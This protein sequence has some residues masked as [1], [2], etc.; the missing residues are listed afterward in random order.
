M[1][2]SIKGYKDNSPDRGEKSLF[3]NS[4]TLT[5]NGVSRPITAIPIINGKPDY[6]QRV[7]L[8]PG[9]PDYTNPKAQGFLEIP[10][11]Q[12][13][14]TMPT[15]LGTSPFTTNSF[16]NIAYTGAFTNAQQQGEMLLPK[17]TN[18]ALPEGMRD[19]NSYQ[20]MMAGSN[21]MS[22]SEF[23]RMTGVPTNFDNYLSP[24]TP[25]STTNNTQEETSEQRLQKMLGALNNGASPDLQ[26]SLQNLGWS[27][28]FNPSEFNHLSPNAQKKLSGIN[29]GLGIASAG[30][31][32]M[33]GAFEVVS[34]M[35]A[36][37]RDTEDRMSMYDKWAN[38]M[39]K[40][41]T[42][43]MQDGGSVKPN[44]QINPDSF[45]LRQDWSKKGKGYFG[46]LPTQSGSV[47][48]EY[49]VGFDYGDVPTLTPD[50]P[51]Y[52]IEYLQKNN[53]MGDNEF[54]NELIYTYADNHARKRESQGLPYFATE[55][56]EG[57]YKYQQGGKILTDGYT[58]GLPQGS[59]LP[60][61]AEVEKGE[62]LKDPQTGQVSEVIGK[63]HSEGGEVMNLEGGTK[64]ISDY[65]EIGS[66]LAREFKKEFDL[67]NLTPK[68]T[69]A[70]VLKR[71]R[72]SIGLT[73]KYDELEKTIN[74]IK[75]Q[76]EITNKNT[77]EINLQHLSK[78]Y[79][80]QLTE[81]EPLEQQM[82]RF[83]DYIFEHQEYKK[84][85][86]KDGKNKFQ[87]GGEVENEMLQIVD[88]FCNMTGQDPNQVLADLEQMSPEEQQQALQMMVEAIQQAPQQQQEEGQEMMQEG[89]EITDE[90]V[91]QLIVTFAQATGANPEEIL[92][93]FQQM[94]PE[95]QTQALQQ[96]A[97]FLQQQTQGGQEQ[98]MAP[99]EGQEMMMQAGGES[100]AGG[101][102]EVMMIIQAFAQATGE[103]AEAIIQQLQQASPEE[104]Q[105]MLQQMVQ[106]LQEGQGQQEMVANE[107]GEEIMQEG[108]ETSPDLG[109]V[110]LAYAQATGQDPQ[111]LAQSLQELSEEELQ[112]ELE[113]MVS[114]LQNV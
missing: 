107:G 60:P 66:K 99:E 71:F 15:T 43:Y 21:T 82:S 14:I 46:E 7:T 45:G 62:L 49:S 29:T 4:N 93:Q 37:K 90:D 88:A 97:Q 63:R 31:A 67:K 80:E 94:S 39:K 87:E 68:S 17:T 75:D 61:N 6:T 57:M 26:S 103:S 8:K 110:I 54:L 11:A 64:V 32:L 20:R 18:R 34:A 55:N 112:M 95:E 104:Q 59:P 100:Q 42:V 33:K 102:E 40:Q 5:M 12:V 23:N 83:T 109:Q 105:Q 38:Q 96:M 85:E 70:T 81:I 1:K 28:G 78:K 19:Y 22:E 77:Q 108:G 52:L 58:T 44:S 91:Q 111:T 72:D 89:G 27:I 86:K 73:K 13:G 35:G 76:E 84:V 69:F 10:N 106:F 24:T 113:R 65:L 2:I 53:G 50:T 9:D 25:V 74:K 16:G 41:N 79:R 114:E 98:Q 36:G 3:I 48:T 47:M 30:N 101:E 51:K 56:E 92:Q